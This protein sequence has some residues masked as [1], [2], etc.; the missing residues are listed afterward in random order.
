MLSFFFVSRISSTD[1]RQK[2]EVKVSLEKALKA[3]MSLG[4]NLTEA[5]VYVFLAKKGPH[6]EKQ[7]AYALNASDQQLCKSLRNM[8]KKGFVTLKTENQ[9]VFIAVPLEKVIDN[10]VKAK[11]EETERMEQNKENFLSNIPQ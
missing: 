3:L 9:T 1:I 6:E 2:D 5:Q 11:T 7:L 10:I 4:L 8:Q